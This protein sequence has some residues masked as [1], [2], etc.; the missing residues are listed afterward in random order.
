MGGTMSAA[1]HR[2][3]RQAHRAHL[4]ARQRE[5]RRRRYAT[6]PAYREAR[7]V[8]GRAAHWWKPT[9]TV[10]GQWCLPIPYTGHPLLEQARALAGPAWYGTHLYDPR[11]EDEAGAVVVALVA[12]SDPREALRAHRRWE[13][14]WQYHE[15]PRSALR[16]GASGWWNWRIA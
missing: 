12:G 3:Y 8:A 6:E 1:Y 13:N 16:P 14:A 11:K 7:R 10:D 2:A 9:A 4:N 5:R 15:V